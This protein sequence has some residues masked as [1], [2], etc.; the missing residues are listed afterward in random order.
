MLHSFLTLALNV[1]E[2]PAEGTLAATE[3]K[4]QQFREYNRP[5]HFGQKSFLL[6]GTEATDSP[7]HGL[8][9]MPSELSWL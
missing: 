5:G 2:W 8:V 9:T 4:V 7:A 3:Q 1:G 6:P